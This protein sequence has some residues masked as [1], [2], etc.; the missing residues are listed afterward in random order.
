M[1]RKD[2]DYKLL[3]DF[4]QKHFVIQE[5]KFVQYIH[6]LYPGR[7]ILIESVLHHFSKTLLMLVIYLRK[8]I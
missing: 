5:Q 7:L 1:K 6:R 8:V 2:V 4:F 3:K